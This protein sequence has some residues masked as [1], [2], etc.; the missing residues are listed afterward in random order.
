[1]AI[2]P[3]ILCLLLLP[4][5][6]LAQGNIIQNGGFES[7]IESDN[8][9][10]GV[11][12]QGHL[13]GFTGNLT[14]L[15]EKGEIA[16]CNMPVSLA[17]ADFNKDGL[18]D[19]AAADPLGYVRYHLNT[20]SKGEPKFSSAVPTPPFLSGTDR[21]PPKDPPGLGGHTRDLIWAERRH[22]VR[23]SLVNLS[24]GKLGLVAGNYIG[25]IFLVPQEGSGAP[26]FAQ[27]EALNK[28]MLPLYKDENIRWGNLFAPV[29]HDWDGDGKADLIVGE[30]S[31]S[32]N[33]V[34]FFPNQGSTDSPVF[35]MDSR[36]VIAL[37]EGRQQLSP[38]V[39]DIN[40]D[41]QDDLLV[42]DSR[43]TLTAYIRPPGWKKG[44][45]IKP[46]GYLAQA[47]GLT[48]PGLDDEKAR[49]QALVLDPA[50]GI[51]TVSTGDL[52]GDGLF[53]LVAGKPD[54]MIAWA[55]NEGTKEQPKFGRPKSLTGEKS[56][57]AAWFQPAAWQCNIGLK[58]GNA[59][60]YAS[61]VSEQEEPGVEPQEGSRALKFG[62]TANQ[63]S[64]LA[65]LKIPAAT[66]FKIG[67][68]GEASPD[69]D[70]FYRTSTDNRLLPASNRTFV[71]Q[72]NIQMEPGKPY[73]LSFKHK[74]AG[75]V[76]ANAFIAWRGEKKLGESEIKRGSR[77]EATEA[78]LKWAEEG[79][80]M[81]KDFKP[82]S[83]WGTFEEKFTVNFKDKNLKDLKK[84][85]NAIV[86][87]MFEL[88]SPEGVLYLD[89]MKL[90]PG[91]A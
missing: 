23:I 45:S 10:P 77:G 60:A 39:V 61:C 24:G 69:H 51:H 50:G 25:E 26:T 83:G 53:D 68:Y 22:G 48:D 3:V 40:G 47:G 41:G 34:H 15:N 57:P 18:P 82:G 43:A 52:N 76:R 87:I 12:K 86:I 27:P 58:R 67:D 17:V 65:K 7:T 84:T 74:G 46:T 35:N 37:G 70:N 88:A 44:D 6:A 66:N 8:L 64:P 32:A 75:I 14:A 89:D 91:A 31:Y 71:M 21:K 90:V 1:M 54:G 85:S 49:A 81:S 29:M 72:Q 16:G 56:E 62:F 59:F 42:A 4:T 38:A 11:D 63:G 73:T 78:N 79:D 28:A 13:A 80:K 9:W 30:G 19:I 20:G 36:S 33:N 2:L 55:P 5:A